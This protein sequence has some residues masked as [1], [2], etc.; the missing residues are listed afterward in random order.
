MVTFEREA[1][2]RRALFAL[3][4]CTVLS[5]ALPGCGS[6]KLELDGTS[7]KAVGDQSWGQVAPGSVVTFGDTCN[8]YS[9]WDRWLLEE[10]DDGYTLTVTGALGGSSEFVVSVTDSSHIT[11]TKGD[12]VLELE[13]QD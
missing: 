13:R 1:L 10:S 5:V 11:L 2:T 6:N 8:I 4:G 3:A 7:W 12:T 9:P